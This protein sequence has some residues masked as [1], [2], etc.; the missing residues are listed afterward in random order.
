V[1]SFTEG[2]ELSVKIVIVGNGKVGFTLAEQ[3]VKENHDITIVDTN[4]QALRRGTDVLDIMAVKGNCV[5][6]AVLREAGAEN[7]D[8]LVAVTNMDEVNMICCLTAR[9]LGVK[10]TIARIRNPEYNSALE[11]LKR[12]L[13]I[14]MTINPEYATAIEISRLLRFPSATNIETFC[15]GRVELMGFRLQADDFMVGK[16]LKDLSGQVKKLSILFCAVDRNGEVM[17]PNGAFVPQADDKVYMIGRPTGLTQFFRLLGRHAPKV[18][19]VLIVGGGKISSYLA[20]LLLKMKMQVKLIEYNEKRCRQLSEAY[21]DMVVICGDGSDQ[22]VLESENLNSFDAFVALTGRDE[23][24]MIVSLYAAQQGI[25]KVVTKSNRQNYAGIARAVGLDSVIS[26]KVITASHILK[27]VRGM[28]NSQ[29][30]VMN[31]LYRIADGAAEAMEFS[32]TKSTRNLGIPLKDLKLKTGILLA[33]VVRGNEII[34]PEGSTSIKDGDAVIVISKSPIQDINDIYA[35]S[36]G[37]GGGK[38]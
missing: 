17:I 15:R 16:P 11:E 25:S 2:K 9:K 26:P 34:I 24:N 10:Y 37:A 1:G 8:L 7:A 35:D 4:E 14:H 6:G 22:E 13:G 33:V 19:R 18:N 23:D 27:V 5:S 32:V 20:S 21:P 31:A 3:L 28:E 29:G 30:S 38:V 12:D 36:F